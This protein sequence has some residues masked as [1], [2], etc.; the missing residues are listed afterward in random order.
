MVELRVCKFNYHL[1]RFGTEIPHQILSIWKTAKLRSDIMSFKQKGGENLYQAWDRFKSMLMSC[2]H[3]HQSNEVLVHTFIEG[4]EPNTNILL[5]STA[6]GHALKKTYAELFTLLN[7]ISK[8]NSEWNGGGMKPV[9]QKIAEYDEYTFQQHDIGTT[10]CAGK[11]SFNN[12]RLGVRSTEVAI[13]LQSN[14]N[15]YQPQAQREQP[16]Q[17]TG[18]ISVEEML[19]KIMADQAQLAAD[20]RNNQLATQNLEK[21]FGQFACAQN[22]RPQGG[23]PGNTNPN[24][25]QVNALNTHSGLQLEELT[26]KER[27]TEVINTESEPK[28]GKLKENEVVAPEE[29]V[30]SIVIPPLPFPQK[31]KK[32]KEDECFGKFLS[33]LKQVHIN[34]PL[35][36]VLQGI[37]RYAK[38]VKKIVANKKRL[39]EYKNVALTEEFNSRIQNKLPI[40]LKDPGSFTV[41]ITI[42][43]S[44]HARGLCDLGASINLMSTS[45]YKKL[46]LGSP[47]PTTIILQL[48]DRSIARLEGVVEDVLVQV[49]Y[50]IFP[51]DF[52]VLNF[53]PDPE[54]HFILGRPFL[55][56]G[57]AMID[58][59]VGQLTMRAHDKV[60]V[61]DVYKALKLP[62]VY[63]ELSS[64]TAINLE[65]EAKYIAAKVPLE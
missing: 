20:V 46:G 24:P 32:Q 54:I 49:G 40:K 47:K 63:N 31:F 8:G 60:E 19:K 30:Q 44:I 9:V 28:E 7:R 50:L 34:L 11:C 55:A 36:D 64:I 51:I 53:E 12:H 2:P 39:T 56:T 15:G 21:Q 25:K 6:G 43:Q 26:P 58:V 37:P 4:L 27:N 17:Q 62:A 18:N 48:A 45:L 23:L 22:S 1:G 35:V 10:A 14:A 13:T 42:G 41:Q 59:A 38:Y 52:V 3:H 57:R 33:L 5:D 61:F 16:K 29:S 65:A